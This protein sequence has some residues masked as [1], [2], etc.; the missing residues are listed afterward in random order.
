MMEFRSELMCS[1]L[2]VWV[3]PLFQP[4]MWLPRLMSNSL[5]MFD[6]GCS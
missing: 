4:C 2:H 1:F 5:G 3:L 6:M